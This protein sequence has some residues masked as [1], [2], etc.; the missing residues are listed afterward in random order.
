MAG[1]LAKRLLVAV[2]GLVAAGTVIVADA[3]PADA[4]QRHRSRSYHS[5]DYAHSHS[6]Q[7]RHYPRHHVAR[8]G[9]VAGFGVAAGLGLLLTQPGT[10]GATEMPVEAPIGTSDHAPH[11]PT[12]VVPGGSP[13]GATPA[14]LLAPLLPLL[15]GAS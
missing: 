9:L 6:A 7:R 12:V 15:L 11:D 13:E 2:I 3:A 10:V 1:N 4:G 14:E 5:R 8:S